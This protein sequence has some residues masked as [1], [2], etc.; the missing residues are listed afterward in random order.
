MC[1]FCTHSGRLLPTALKEG[2]LKCCLSAWLKTHDILCI[3]GEPEI[4]HQHPVLEDRWSP[5]GD[6]SGEACSAEKCSNRRSGATSLSSLRS[7][8]ILS[9][10]L[11]CF[12]PP[13]SFSFCHFLLPGV[14]YTSE[15]FPCKPGTFSHSP[16]SS[17][18]D[19]CP[20]DTYSGRGASSCTPCNTTTQF[21]GKKN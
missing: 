20:P 16:G 18:C 3:L 17:T 10:R 12:H 8:L 2:M 1:C 15:C 21:A 9:V 11:S 5:D 4:W 6:Q 13:S 19:P 7:A 14:A